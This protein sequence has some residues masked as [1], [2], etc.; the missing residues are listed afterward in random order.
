MAEQPTDATSSSKLKGGWQ[1]LV[2]TIAAWPLS[3]KIALAAVT[4]LTLGMF[5]LIIV[6]ARTAEYQL[7]YGNLA[8]PDASSVINWLKGQ[9]IPYQLD[10]NGHNILIPAKDVHESRLSLASLGLPQGGGVGF[11][12][13][14]KQSFA[15]TDFVQK[16]NYSR[17]LQGELSRT[18]AS[19]GPVET[20][21][22]HLALPEKRLFKDQQQPATA[23]VI[24][25]LAPGKRLNETQ[26]EGIVHLVSS[27]IEGL[28]PQRVTIID[29][30][31]NVLS[32]LGEKGL[33]GGI[34]PDMLE[35]Q[36]QVEQRLEDRAQ[37]L[38]DK[39]LGA[40]NAMVR[41]SAT[42]DFAKTEKTEETFDPEEPVIR[43]E[44]VNEEKSGSEI[45]GGVPGV[46]S[47][48]EGNTNQAAG[49][50]SPTSRSQRTTNYEI[51]KVVS[52]TVNPIGTISKL[53]VSVLVADKAV[54]AKDGE[55]A[56]T[57]A[58]S[59]AELKAL[60]TMVGSALGLDQARGDKIE[61]TSL[62]FLAAADGGDGGE[63]EAGSRVYQYIP[64]IRYGLLA[65]GCL[66]LYFLLVKPLMKTLNR[67]VTQHYKTV[68]QMEAEQTKGAAAGFKPEETDVLIGGAAYKAAMESPP[69]D[70]LEKVR[71]GVEN[72]PVFSA[73]VLKG[74]IHEQG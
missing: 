68:E 26:I 21:R 29:Q 8:D 63:G 60:E 65:L 71:K 20:A 52:K 50:S 73:H 32:R 72:D 10:N 11:E 22:V 19:L 51:S 70:A 3:R 46:Q 33:A 45:V 4:A 74:W 69:V 18:I 53:S 44:Q 15:L 13:F 30:N 17:A 1:A 48:L 42:L 38:L 57:E 37:T 6:Q 24:I 31:G 54:P 67:D 47:N 66:V 55:T 9:N 61:V 7:L 56:R 5:A 16:V 41:V 43:S 62:P 64:L 34:S 59:P 58:R 23:S 35:F 49:A 2:T 12:I 28:D 39:S 36:M 40:K 14:D 25:K 27:S